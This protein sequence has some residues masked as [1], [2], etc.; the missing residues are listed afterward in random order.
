LFGALAGGVA[1]AVLFFG[2]G[3]PATGVVGGNLILE[4]GL[5]PAAG[6]ADLVRLIAESLVGIVWWSHGTFWAALLVGT[7]LGAIG[8]LLTPPAA[9]PSD[10]SDLRLGAKTILTA[11]A[12][13]STFTFCAAVV[14][15][16]LLESVTHNALVKHGVSLE[17]TLPL[18]GISLW[19][20][21]TPM[22]F[23]VA[24]LVAVYLPV[25]AEIKTEDPAR[26]NAAR[27]TAA[28][29]GFVSFGVPAYLRIVNPDLIRTR[30]AL[31]VAAIVTVTIS[32]V[33]G[34]LYVAAIIQTRR[35]RRALGLDRPHPI[36]IVAAI[37]A[38]LSLGIIVWAVALPPFFSLLAALVAIIADV[39]LIVI[40]RRQ[41]KPP[42]SDTITLAQLR[43][44]MSQSIN[45]G[46]G[47]VVAM[48]VPLMATISASLSIVMLTRFTPVLTNYDMSEQPY[49]PDYTLVELVRDAYLT[50]AR[51][52]LVSFV[53]AIAIVGLLM[54]VI[55]GIITIVKR[56]SAQ[57][58]KMV[59]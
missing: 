30:S 18:E 25:R 42:P 58:A 24:S 33:L 39:V 11:A 23:Y 44:T 45:A 8:G 55:S 21:G 31:G 13:I 52:F 47:S 41:P 29:F 59:Q 56:R 37:G 5:I 53:G 14:V 9:E 46:L 20:I 16:T 51:A 38:L 2:I 12:L 49:V 10:R 15:F 19:L 7:G 48:I 43:L 26:L 32:L 3:A 50:Q 54:L 4:H 1:G 27:I 28:V 22:I 57:N 40:L 17:T 36:R 35:R 34:G 6:N